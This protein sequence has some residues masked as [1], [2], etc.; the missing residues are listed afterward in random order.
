MRY[1]KGV[2]VLTLEQKK[3]LG[4]IGINLH[5]YVT[6]FRTIRTSERASKM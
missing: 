6:R 2:T 3:R 1:I 4:K 5:F